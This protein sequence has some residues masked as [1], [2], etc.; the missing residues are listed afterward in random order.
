MQAAWG[1]WMSEHSKMITLTEE[2]GSYAGKS[3]TA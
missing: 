3:V 1:K 2:G